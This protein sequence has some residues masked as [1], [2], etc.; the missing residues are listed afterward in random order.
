MQE[1]LCAGKDSHQNTQRKLSDTKQLKRLIFVVTNGEQNVSFLPLNC[2]ATAESGCLANKP[3]NHS[4][5]VTILSYPYHSV[6]A[7]RLPLYLQLINA[8]DKTA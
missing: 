2:F 8:K 1:N 6:L 4:G 7:D 3:T 5:Q